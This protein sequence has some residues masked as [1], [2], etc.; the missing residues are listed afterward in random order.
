MFWVKNF[1]CLLFLL[2]LLL[3]VIFGIF[4]EEILIIFNWFVF[5][6]GLLVIVLFFWLLVIWGWFVFGVEFFWLDIYCLFCLGGGIFRLF[7]VVDVLFRDV[8]GFVFEVIEGVLFFGL[9]FG[10]LGAVG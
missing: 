6:K 4:L 3:Y 5:F 10:D 2:G 8:A 1:F 7:I 9:Y